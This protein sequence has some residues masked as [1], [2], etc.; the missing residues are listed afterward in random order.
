MK[1][2]FGLLTIALVTAGLTALAAGEP[3]PLDKLPKPVAESVKKRFPK[4]EMKAASKGETADKKTVFE[5]S[6]KQDGK[7]IDVSL[8][9]EGAITVIEKEHAFKDL[10][11][12]V[13]DTFSKKY[14][15]ATYTI[16]EEVITVAGGKETTEYYEAILVT[17]DKKTFEAEVFPDGKFKGEAERKDEPK[18]DEK[19][20]GAGWSDDFSAEK[21]DLTPT[22]RNPYFILE[23]GYQ[24]VFED[25]TERLVIT[26]LDE[27]KMVDGVE[28][29]VIEER[30][31][32]GG[33]LVEVSRNYFAIGKRSNSVYYFGEDVDIYKDGKVVSH[34]GAWLAGRNGARFGLM[35]PGLPL[36]G[37][38]YYQEVAPKEA[39]DRSEIVSVTETVKTPAGE[40]KNCLKVEE[41]TPLEPAVK[42][43]KLYGPGVGLLQA[44]NLK[45]VKYG[46]VDLPKK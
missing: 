6:L 41:T 36:V 4:A 31:T 39:M 5:V 27:T 32:K 18:K 43:F 37:A 44:D 15:N 17:A 7:N 33:Q 46:K 34:D 35:M 20:G 28:C 29:R 30:E 16:I 1:L 8:T 23:P 12:A 13:A 40:F 2:V 10:P 38:R 25:G 26:V 19:K 24:Q 14:P 21:G 3:V 9:S 22:G 45:L 11:K 42:E